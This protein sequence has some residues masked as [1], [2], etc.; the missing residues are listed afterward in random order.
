[1]LVS[2][3]P[4]AIVLQVHH[5]E[6]SIMFKTAMTITACIHLYQLCAVTQMNEQPEEQLLTFPA[7]QTLR[8]HFTHISVNNAQAWTS[9][10]RSEY[11][12]GDFQNL[13]L[14]KVNTVDNQS[15]KKTES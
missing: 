13:H 2:S 8:T 1:M 5:G 15:T 6:K 14:Q 11:H 7:G 4:V 10:L 12:P 9:S 3:I